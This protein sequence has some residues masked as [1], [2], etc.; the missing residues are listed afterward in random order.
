VPQTKTRS[1]FE[2]DLDIFDFKLTAEEIARLA[3]L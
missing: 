3:V 1:H 2:E